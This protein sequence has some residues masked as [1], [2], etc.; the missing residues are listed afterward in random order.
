MAAVVGFL[1]TRA[2]VEETCGSVFL[3]TIPC[4]NEANMVVG[5]GC[6]AVVLVVKSDRNSLGVEGVRRGMTR[7]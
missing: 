7:I 5:D 2:D 3:E 4:F 6:V 1:R